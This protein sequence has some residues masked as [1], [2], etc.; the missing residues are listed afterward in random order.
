MKLSLE[1]KMIKKIVAVKSLISDDIESKGKITAV[2]EIK[3]K[4][5]KKILTALDPKTS[6]RFCAK[7][8]KIR[9]DLLLTKDE[10]EIFCLTNAWHPLHFELLQITKDKLHEAR[11]ELN[12]LKILINS[13][14]EQSKPHTI[15]SLTIYDNFFTVAYTYLKNIRRPKVSLQANTLISKPKAN[16]IIPALVNLIKSFSVNTLDL[17]E[18]QSSLFVTAYRLFGVLQKFHDLTESIKEKD[19]RTIKIKIDLEIFKKSLASFLIQKNKSIL[20]S[21]KEKA[22]ENILELMKAFNNELKHLKIHQQAGRNK[23]NEWKEVSKKK[24]FPNS[25]DCAEDLEW[26]LFDILRFLTDISEIEK[27][28]QNKTSKIKNNYLLFSKFPDLLALNCKLTE[29]FSKLLKLTVSTIWES[30]FRIVTNT[31]MHHV[32]DKKPLIEAREKCINGSL[33]K[34]NNNRSF[35]LNEISKQCLKDL[36]A[37]F[38]TK[39]FDKKPIKSIK[40]ISGLMQGLSNKDKKSFISKNHNKLQVLFNKIIKNKRIVTSLEKEDFPEFL[41]DCKIISECMAKFPRELPKPNHDHFD[42]SFFSV[43][44]LE[45][46]NNFIAKT[47]KRKKNNKLFAFKALSILILKLEE[48]YQMRKSINR[49]KQTFGLDKLLKFKGQIINRLNSAKLGAVQYSKK[50]N[51]ALKFYIACF[52]IRFAS[53]TGSAFPDVAQSINIIKDYILKPNLRSNSNSL[54]PTNL[55]FDKK[56]DITFALSTLNLILESPGINQ[57]RLKSLAPITAFFNKTNIS[58][59]EKLLKTRTNR[60]KSPAD[61][62]FRKNHILIHNFLALFYKAKA[63]QPNAILT[64]KNEFL[65]KAKSSIEHIVKQ[66]TLPKIFNYFV[67][68]DKGIGLPFIFYIKNLSDKLEEIHTL[69]KRTNCVI[70]LGLIKLIRDYLIGVEYNWDYRVD[71]QQSCTIWNI[72]QDPIV[73]RSNKIITKIVYSATNFDSLKSAVLSLK[74]TTFDTGTR[75]TFILRSLTTA[76]LEDG[77]KDPKVKLLLISAYEHLTTRIYQLHPTKMS[78][79]I[80]NNLIAATKDFCLQLVLSPD[81]SKL[82]IMNEF[83]DTFM[84]LIRLQKDLYTVKYPKLEE[85]INYWANKK[86]LIIFKALFDL[87]A[88]SE[89]AIHT[90]LNKKEVNKVNAGSNICKILD[91]LHWEQAP[92]IKDLF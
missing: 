58:T 68:P 38:S 92:T 54:S 18:T 62:F 11:T 17:N 3:F 7:I 87:A 9:A 70:D 49:E 83:Q 89:R 73:S 88:F 81:F 44:I 13:A 6:I 36:N 56:Y 79:D 51:D 19:P 35:I 1:N 61:L 48:E 75:F 78:K 45:L 21:A 12:G 66:A 85:K 65:A 16:G 64:E 40:I 2:L 14:K 8:E 80:V 23:I 53:I 34:K 31:R 86:K 84:R 47:T 42:Q 74:Y 28:S 91:I 32:E 76:L 4:N 57:S 41:N 25:I 15:K 29:S 52:K 69:A 63:I 27:Q 39:D 22:N 60:I 77:M 50:N 72:I 90:N 55:N 43:I 67:A 24:R 82:L 46:T 5:L 26:H 59:L 37:L 10:S 71:L 20:I 30:A 33:S